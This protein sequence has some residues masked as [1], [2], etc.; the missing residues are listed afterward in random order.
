MDIPDTTLVC[1]DCGVNFI[2]TDREQE[3][4]AERGFVPPSRCPACRSRRRAER[5]A[6]GMSSAV[7][8]GDGGRR[9]RPLFAALCADC[10]RDTMVPFEP[11]PGRPV[12][13]RQCF[14]AHRGTYRS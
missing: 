6:L 5:Q 2:F 9:P 7:A 12:Y 14:A 4:Y 1:R 13:C 11:K 10:G 8:A 3:F